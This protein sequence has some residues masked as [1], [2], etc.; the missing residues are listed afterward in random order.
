P[1]PRTNNGASSSFPPRK[2]Q[3]PSAGAQRQL[4]LPLP[5]PRPRTS[6]QRRQSAAPFRYPIPP[7]V[8]LSSSLSSLVKTHLRQHQQRHTA[9]TP[10]LAAPVPA[11][12]QGASTAPDCRIA[13]HAPPIFRHPSPGWFSAS[14]S[15]SCVGG[16]AAIVSL[17]T[18][19]LGSHTSSPVSS[20]QL[21]LP[22]PPQP[23]SRSRVDS[24]SPPDRIHRL[25]RL[26]PS[27]PNRLPTTIP[28]CPSS[29]RRPQLSIPSAII[30]SLR[31]RHHVVPSS[32]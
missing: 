2:A 11:P 15:S 27:P 9:R 1:P 5:R 23:L 18:A 30:H 13:P 28:A 21:Q 8:S 20:S 29:P 4:P 10:R 24:G 26:A 12:A 25:A 17:S 32:P 7:A 16:D 3:H 31:R 6:V 19:L 22:L 14:T